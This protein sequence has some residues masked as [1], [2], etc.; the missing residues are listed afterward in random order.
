MLL[1]SLPFLEVCLLPLVVLLLFLMRL[2]F[3]ASW[4]LPVASL[5]QGLRLWMEVC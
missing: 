1:V 3:L 5:L 2:L 4:L